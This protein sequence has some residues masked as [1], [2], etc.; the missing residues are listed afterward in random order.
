MEEEDIRV[1][2]KNRRVSTVHNTDDATIDIHATLD[3]PRS[4]TG[5]EISRLLPPHPPPLP[6]SSNQQQS[7]FIIED[8]P[9][10]VV[11][12]KRPLSRSELS[13]GDRDVLEIRQNGIVLVHEPKT[14]VDLTRVVE[15]QTFIFD[16]AFDSNEPNELIYHRTVKPLVDFIF[17]G[18]KATCFAYGQTGS[19]KVWYYGRYLLS[20]Q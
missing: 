4:S 20:P 3:P 19:G 14:K 18:G 16:D 13:K 2:R 6:S 8:M 11:I 10:R 7:S 15:T 17:T 12:R 5:S 9:I 1:L